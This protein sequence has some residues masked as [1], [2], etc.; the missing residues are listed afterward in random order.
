[1]DIGCHVNPTGPTTPFGTQNESH[2][3]DCLDSSMSHATPF[4]V[5]HFGSK[6]ASVFLI[7]YRFSITKNKYLTSFKI[8]TDFY[9]C[10]IEP[11]EQFLLLTQVQIVHR[12]KT[13]NA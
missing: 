3:F 4:G 5:T 12:L 13:K 11:G 6:S 8:Y 10:R 9:T 7:I 2:H 1:M